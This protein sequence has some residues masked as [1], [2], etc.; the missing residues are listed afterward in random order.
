M[1][2]MVEDQWIREHEPHCYNS[3]FFLI[4]AQTVVDGTPWGKIKQCVRSTDG[5]FAEA[6]GRRG[7]SVSRATFLQWKQC[8]VPSMMEVVLC[9]QIPSRGLGSSLW[10]TLST[11]HRE[12]LMRSRAWV[13]R[14][15]SQKQELEL[16]QSESLV[17]VM[18]LTCDFCLNPVSSVSLPLDVEVLLL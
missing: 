10:R 3:F 7:N 6:L 11:D 13:E 14:W 1:G 12:L 17:T 2:N 15:K 16:W 9:N 8:A 18:P 4:T 5:D